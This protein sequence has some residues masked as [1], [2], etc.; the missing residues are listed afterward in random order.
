MQYEY[1]QHRTLRVNDEGEREIIA[2]F[3]AEII[4]ETRFSDGVN[5]KTKLTIVGSQANPEDPQ[6]DPIKLEEITIDAE[7]FNGMGWVMPRWGVRALIYPVPNVKED[8]RAAIQSISKPKVM[9]VYRHTGWTEIDGKR[10]YLHRGGAIGPKGNNPNVLVE[11]P[12]ELSRYDLVTVA[13]SLE[14]VKATLELR[15]LT[16][17][18]VSWPL[19]L[20]GLAPVFGPIDFGV[21]LAGRTGTF[22]SEVMS[23]IQSHYGAGMDARHLPGSWSSTANALEA[24]AFIAKN[25]AFVIDD[26]VPT[27]TSWQQRSYQANADKIVRSQGNQSGRSRLTDVS[28]LQQTMYPR[29]IILSTGEDVPEGHSV[30]ARLMILELSPGDI[31]VKALTACQSRRKLYTATVAALVQHLAE[32]NPDLTEGV[33][34][35]REQYVEIGHSRTPGMLAKLVAV[36][37]YFLQWAEQIGAISNKDRVKLTKEATQAIV[38]AGKS[39]TQYLEES[40]PTDVFVAGI[41]QAVATG[42]GHFRTLNGGIPLSAELLGWTQEQSHGE[43]PTYK[44]RGPCIGWVKRDVD[45]MYLDVTAGYAVVKKACGAELA[46]SKNTLIKRLKDAG[47]LCRVDDG[48]GR[49]TVR[50]TAEQHPRQVLC[51]PI[52]EVLDTNEVPQGEEDE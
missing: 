16:K 5:T 3:T 6:G 24:Q 25:A 7:Q 20:G 17:P 39:Q 9:T 26:F 10:A 8:C 1:L 48:R 43:L 50:I 11:L 35:L 30:R 22:K 40:D 14:A 19:I 52:S 31:D 27:G 2:N 51:L 4:Q 49:N 47:K 12:P 45:E 44:S 42:A 18:E 13:D 23:L 29:G 37:D 33:E 32:A 28:E 21:H 34:A 41:K 38:T 36:A 46:L 15:K